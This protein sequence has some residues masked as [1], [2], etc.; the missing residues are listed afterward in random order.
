MAGHGLIRAVLVGAVF[1]LNACTTLGPDFQEPE[2]G[3]LDQWQTNLYGQAVT[4]DQRTEADL[5]FW[6]RLFDDPEALKN[7]P[8]GS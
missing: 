6:W 1:V 7:L 2:V 3:W 4:G 5:R 8:D